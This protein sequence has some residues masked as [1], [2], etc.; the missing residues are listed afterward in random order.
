MYLNPK[1]LPAPRL[2]ITWKHSKGKVWKATYSLVIRLREKDVRH[3][4]ADDT[5]L[6]HIPMSDGCGAAHLVGEPVHHGTISEPKLDGVHAR[7][8]SIALTL[9]VYIVCGDK[10]VQQR[11]FPEMPHVARM[12][13][14]A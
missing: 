7:W 1:S 3:T 8:D 14:A 6:L 9:P 4:K 2:Q 11:L 5:G 13:A 10:A 12:A